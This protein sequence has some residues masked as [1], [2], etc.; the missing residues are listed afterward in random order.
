MRGD[1][2]GHIFWR[3]LPFLGYR[4]PHGEDPGP[5]FLALNVGPGCFSQELRTRPC[6][7]PCNPIYVTQER[8]LK[9]YIHGNSAH[10][11]PLFMSSMYKVCISFVNAGR[12]LGNL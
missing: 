10:K 12:N 3:E 7:G 5:S 1:F 11:K 2:S 4:P 9:R 6:F 8:V